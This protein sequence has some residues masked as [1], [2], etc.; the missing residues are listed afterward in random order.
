MCMV[1]SMD[2]HWWF[3]IDATYIRIQRWSCLMF[4]GINIRMLASIAIDHRFDSLSVKSNKRQYIW[5][6]HF[7]ATCGLLLRGL[8]L[9]LW[10]L[11]PL[12]TILMLYQG[13]Q[14]YLW[15]KPEKTTNL[16]QV[17][18]KLY[19]I[20]LYRVHLAISGIRSRNAIDDRHCLQLFR[21]ASTI[22]I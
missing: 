8:W 9:W 12:S 16:S 19:H 1:V 3:S 21:W 7:V 13:C 20:M 15:R 14:L 11:T 17:T 4:N 10:R 2:I 6:L 18:D 22:N 5:Y